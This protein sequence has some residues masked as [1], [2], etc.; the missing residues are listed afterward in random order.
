MLRIAKN[1]DRRDEG[2]RELRERSSHL[3]YQILVLG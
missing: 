2:R 3:T 1:G